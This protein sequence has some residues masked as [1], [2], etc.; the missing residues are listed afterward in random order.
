MVKTVLALAAATMGLFAGVK[1]FAPEGISFGLLLFAGV[2]V[3][4]GGLLAADVRYLRINLVKTGDSTIFHRRLGRSDSTTLS[5]SDIK[6]V[7][8]LEYT[9]IGNGSSGPNDILRLRIEGIGIVNVAETRQKTLRAKIIRPY[10]RAGQKIAD[11]V[12]VDYKVKEI[13]PL[14]EFMHDP[15]QKDPSE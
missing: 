1:A 14:Q 13:N 11:F 2:F 8:K 10:R 9:G 6:V 7:E 12:G 4:V 15:G 3:A 5:I